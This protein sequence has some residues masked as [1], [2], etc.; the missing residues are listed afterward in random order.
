MCYLI[1]TKL[2]AEWEEPHDSLSYLLQAEAKSMLHHGPAS[3]NV[4]LGMSEQAAQSLTSWQVAVHEAL[5]RLVF[6]VAIAN[7]RQ[8]G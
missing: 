2:E 6:L 4:F 1:S 7:T 8:K 5:A 3:G